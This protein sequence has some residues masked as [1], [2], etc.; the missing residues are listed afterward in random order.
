MIFQSARRIFCILRLSCRPPTL[1]S[2][3]AY[4]GCISDIPA[5]DWRCES[6]PPSEDSPLP[7]LP[8]GAGM[9]LDKIDLFHH[10]PIFLGQ[11]LEHFAGLTF[12]LAGNDLHHVVLAYMKPD[13]FHRKPHPPGPVLQ[14]TSGAREIIFM[15]F[16]AR[17]SRAT[18]PKIRVPTGSFWGVIKTAELSSNLI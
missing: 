7:S 3:C 13:Q 5:G 18:G 6:G 1:F 15:N 14:R 11:N 10:R 16:F 12:F 8:A 17:S 2:P 9:A 4:P